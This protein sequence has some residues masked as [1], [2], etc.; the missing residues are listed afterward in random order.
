MATEAEIPASIVAN[1]LFGIDIDLRAIQLSALTLYLKAKSLNKDAVLTD[2]NLVSADVLPFRQRDLDAF[3]AEMKFELPIYERI[4]KALW[5]KLAEV[6]DLGSLARLEQDVAEAVQQERGRRAKTE[7]ELPLLVGLMDGDSPA[8]AADE[9][10]EIIENQIVGSLGLYAQ[11]MAAKGADVGFFVGETTKGLRLLDVM[12]R[13]YDV[14]V[15]NPPYLTSFTDRMKTSLSRLYPIAKGDTYAAFIQRCTELAASAGRVGMITQQSFMF[16]SSYEKLRAH[17]RDEV[18]TETMAHLGTRAFDEISGEVVSTTAFVLRREPDAAL[19]DSSSGTYFRLVKGPDGESKRVQ[20]EEAV[21]TIGAG[22]VDRLAMRFRQSDF[23]AIPGSPW[24]YWMP[25]RIRA[26]FGNLP[27]LGELAGPKHGL[28]TCNN[29]RYI[30]YWWEVPDDR[31][32]RS[33]LNIGSAESGASRW[34]PLVKGGGSRWHG[35]ERDLVNWM[36]DGA[37]IKANIVQKYPY[38]NGSWGLVVTNPD[39]YFRPGIYVPKVTSGKQRVREYGKGFI[40]DVS[41]SS[42]ISRTG[43]SNAGVRIQIC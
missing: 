34:F 38:L 31:V 39:L 40:F 42:A 24:V 1:N 11:S 2:H 30:R 10:W 8:A 13:S 16:L 32:C 12:R 29:F 20:L 14:V 6:S 4:L 21:S 43:K 22:D 27:F 17:L 5:P 33:R 18:V 15:S 28:S 3:L 41:G 9:Q 23:G 7:R 35:A 26:L 19:R 36:H 37:E 25:P